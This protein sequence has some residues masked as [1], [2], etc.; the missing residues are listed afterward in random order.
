MNC[1]TCQFPIL[2]HMGET[3]R[4]TVD[5]L[6]WNEETKA[7]EGVSSLDDWSAEYILRQKSTDTILT[8]TTEGVGITKSGYS[9]IVSVDASELEGVEPGKVEHEF[10]HT[11]ESGGVTIV[12]NDIITVKTSL[13]WQTSQ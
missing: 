3:L 2:Y 10:N 8:F 5:V 6:I 1:E 12:F 9:F 4:F 13:K 7:Y 11:D